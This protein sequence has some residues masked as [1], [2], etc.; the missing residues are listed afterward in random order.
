MQEI[1]QWVHEGWDKLCNSEIIKED[2]DE[3]LSLSNDIEFPDDIRQ[4][5][6]AKSQIINFMYRGLG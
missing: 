5:F 2:L 3:R 4:T 6:S 1:L